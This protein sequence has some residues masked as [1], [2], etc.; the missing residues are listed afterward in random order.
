ME[1]TLDSLYWR[2]AVKKF[3]PD[4]AVPEAKIGQLGLAFNL[5]ATS[6]GLQ[7]IRLLIVQNKEVQE[8]LVARSYGQRQVADAS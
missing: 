5:T 7:P 2:Y 4:R 1:Q 3:D 8:S 6:Y